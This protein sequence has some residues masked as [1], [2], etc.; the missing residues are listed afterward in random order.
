MKFYWT[1]FI[2]MILTYIVYVLLLTYSIIKI[3]RYVKAYV[4]DYNLKEVLYRDY[5]IFSIMK[6]PYASYGFIFFTL[7]PMV[8]L[9]GY[10][11]VYVFLKEYSRKNILNI[12]INLELIEFKKELGENN[13]SKVFLNPHRCQM[14]KS[15]IN[16]LCDYF[17]NDMCY[18]KVFLL[19]QFLSV[20]DSIHNIFEKLRDK[21]ASDIDMLEDG[22]ET[23]NKIDKAINSTFALLKNHELLYA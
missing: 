14:L 2:I 9:T 22:T 5:N 20:K 18:D 17:S 1:F 10:M 21:N 12:I 13:L 15:K 8:H 6:G 11:F 4:N 23:A 7:I 19:Y 3:N 16:K